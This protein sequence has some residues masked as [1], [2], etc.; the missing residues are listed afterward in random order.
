VPEQNRVLV[1]GGAG[2]VGSHLCERLLDAGSLVVCVDNFCTGEPVNLSTF[3]DH[4]AFEFVQ[5]D[6]TEPSADRRLL[7]PFD[8]VFHLASPASPADYLRLPVETLRV[9]ALGTSFTLDI[10]E[11]CGARLVLAST[12]EVYGDPLEH[13][14][15]ESYWGNVNPIGPRSVYDEAKRFSEA[16]VFAHQR[17]RSVNVGVARIFNTYGPRMRGYDGRMVP[18]FC[19][20]ALAGE[21]LTVT[22]T[23][24]QTRSICHVNDT[25][26]GLMA[27]GNAEISGPVNIGNPVELTVLTVAE[28]IRD[29]SGSESPIEFIAA[30]EDDPQRRCPDVRLARE[31]LGWEPKVSPEEGLAQTVEWFRNEV[32]AGSEAGAPVQGAK[33]T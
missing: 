12:S 28:M 13:P 23:G 20:Q 15:R 16:L 19:R 25:V 10:A 6:I 24:Q 11:K 9:G 21:P 7:G 4:P 3:I 2:F 22:G 18:T 26:A 14:Q 5:H 17:A 31:L 27:L 1:T 29:L 8:T 32:L 30:P 33:S